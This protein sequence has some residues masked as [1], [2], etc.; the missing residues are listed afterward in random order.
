[1]S[2]NLLNIY[3]YTSKEM[4]QTFSLTMISL[5]CKCD[6]RI[7]NNQDVNTVQ[8]IIRASYIHAIRNKEIKTQQFIVLRDEY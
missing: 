6:I 7:A 4:I 8:V 5:L 1:M 2:Q 3:H